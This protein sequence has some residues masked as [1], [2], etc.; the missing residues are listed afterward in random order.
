MNKWAYIA[1]GMAWIAT[2]F[3]VAVGIYYT[4]NASC[5]WAMLIPGFISLTSSKS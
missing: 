1:Y 5:L 3:A 4:K 2:A